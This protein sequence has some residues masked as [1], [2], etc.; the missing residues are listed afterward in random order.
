MMSGWISASP[1]ADLLLIA[2]DLLA[3]RRNPQRHAFGVKSIIDHILS[4]V[5]S[6]S[7]SANPDG[8]AGGDLDLPLARLVICIVDVGRRL[9]D[10]DPSCDPRPT[11][12]RRHHAA[13]ALVVRF[14]H[15]HPVSADSLRML[16]S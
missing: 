3:V 6:W 9:L 16:E 7:R 12:S 14:Q 5:C 4:F 15:S 13:A 10:L 8:Q 2:V 1:P 11:T